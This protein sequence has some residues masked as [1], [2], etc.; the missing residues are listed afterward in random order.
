MRAQLNFR[1]FGHDGWFFISGGGGSVSRIRIKNFHCIFIDSRYT[2]LVRY[3]AS[4]KLLP[5]PEVKETPMERIRA[6]KF[7]KNLESKASH[8]RTAS[9]RMK[10]SRERVG[11]KSNFL[12][13]LFPSG[14]GKDSISASAYFEVNPT[15]RI[16]IDP[17]STATKQRNSP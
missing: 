7:G 6:T 1:I 16:V 8:I 4:S 10:A 13:C 14:A 12:E 9:W 11:R 15:S 2:F 3:V 5:E 17:G